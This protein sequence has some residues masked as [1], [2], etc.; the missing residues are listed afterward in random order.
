MKR[1]AGVLLAGILS[2]WLRGGEAGPASVSDLAAEDGAVRA[3]AAVAIEAELARL[4]KAGDAKGLAALMAPLR[5]ARGSADL[6]QA[7]AARQLLAPYLAGAKRWERVVEMNWAASLSE[8]G[9]LV[10]NRR[11]ATAPEVSLLDARTG[12]AVW[13]FKPKQLNLSP[14]PTHLRGRGAEVFLGAR[15]SI[16]QETS[17]VW[18]LRHPEEAP[19]WKEHPKGILQVMEVSEA[20]LL[21]GRPPEE[22]PGDEQDLLAGWDIDFCL[23]EPSDG[24]TLW[25]S[26]LKFLTGALAVP[27]DGGFLAAGMRTDPSL[28]NERGW[29][30]F[31]DAKTGKILW[32]KTLEGFPET[33]GRA[34]EG[35]LFACA[36]VGDKRTLGLLAFDGPPRQG[37]A[38]R[39]TVQVPA[40]DPSLG[41]CRCLPTGI[42]VGEMKEGA[43]DP[44]S[45]AW[46]IS[47]YGA[48]DG[49]RR[50][51]ERVEL[52]RYD[53]VDI[54]PDGILFKYAL[55]R[56]RVL[57]QIETK[58]ALGVFRYRDADRE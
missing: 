20:G 23:R 27:C 56:N 33:M 14:V 49:A 31:L 24:T 2:G 36:P 51:T 17:P 16:G 19:R 46:E 10:F 40:F 25:T 39:W 43:Q 50:W 28:E 18:S 13:S 3:Q 12:A 37:G 45:Q 34:P 53:I 21:L 26:S 35:I 32:E 52:P 6:D 57:T 29:T 38:V 5:A 48:A 11:G 1:T 55:E 41:F 47:L 54:G 22:K 7:A 9:V 58:V 8:G 42:L 44:L 4:E 30:G 15:A